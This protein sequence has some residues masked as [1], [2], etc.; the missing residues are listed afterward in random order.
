MKTKTEYDK[1]EL[2]ALRDLRD[3][4]QSE[5]NRFQGLIENRLIKI[6]ERSNI[7][8]DKR[9]AERNAKHKKECDAVYSI[10]KTEK[11]EIGTGEL[12]IFLNERLDYPRLYNSMTFATL[13]GKY[14]KADKRITSKFGI[15][16]GIRST[17]W[18]IL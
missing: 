1:M 8:N 3:F 9:I 13:L 14:L 7:Q 4:H 12:C 6:K 10:L 16:N 17:I 18:N 15:I 2:N 11:R 5:V